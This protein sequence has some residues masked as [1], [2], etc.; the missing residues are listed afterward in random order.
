[1]DSESQSRLSWIRFRK[2]FLLKPISVTAELD[3]VQ[4]GFPFK[5]F[6]I[7]E[8]MMNPSYIFSAPKSKHIIGDL[9][10]HCWVLNKP[11]RKHIIGDLLNKQ[12]P[13]LN[14]KP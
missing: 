12:G 10:N 7:H 9:P 5:I 2:D 13:T 8:K 1:M 6:R 3:E 4:K 11:A 14:L